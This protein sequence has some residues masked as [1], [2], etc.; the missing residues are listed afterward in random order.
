MT[1]RSLVLWLWRSYLHPWRWWFGTA[2]L[3]MSIEGSMVGALSYLIK[4]MFDNVFVGGT[5]SSVV[6]VAAAVSGVFLVRALASLGHKLLMARLGERVVAAL[7]GDV[8]RHLLTLDQGFYKVNPPGSLIERTRGDTGALRGLWT[9]VIAALGRDLV[10][11]VSL[12]GVALWM[13]PVWTVLAVAGVPLLLLPIMALQRLVR[14]TSLAARIAAADSATRLDEIYHGVVSVQLSGTEARE[15][16]RY[17]ASQNRYIAAQLRAEA[18]SAGIPALI[19]VVAAIGFGGVLAYGGFQIID[20]EKTVGEFMSFF[21]AMALVFDPLRRLGA[22]SGA[23]QST[24]ASLDRVAAL[25]AIPASI[26]SPA[27][28]APAPRDPATLRI[29]FERVHFAYEDAPVLE[30]LSF[31]AEPGQTTAIVGPSGAGKSTIFALLARMVDP[32]SGRVTLAGTDLHRFNLEELRR[33]YSIVSQET[34]LFDET[35]RDNI[36]M[37]RT[38]VSPARLDEVLAAAHLTDFVAGL[39]AGLDTPAGPR[40]SALSGGQR[41]RVAIARALLRDAPILLLDEATSALDAASERMVQDALDRLASG[42]TTLVIAH[43]LAT[44]RNADKIVVLQAGRVVEQGRHEELVALN[45]V[46]A[47]LSRL[48]FGE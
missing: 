35:L 28:P 9:Q 27:E 10:S 41:Q 4:P 30:D 20:G 13:D 19:D 17:Q 45:G 16:A 1:G 26:T 39:P 8:L 29:A 14:R 43:R 3:L 47:R 38:D 18:G 15:A 21:F 24:R 22:V 48:Q 44:V 2:M 34:A 31:T 11:L 7:Q 23:W 33:R 42:R 46:Y 12:L 6:W 25:L 40:G 37:G 36:L 32:D 5:A